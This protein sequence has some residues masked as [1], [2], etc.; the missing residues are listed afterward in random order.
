MFELGSKIQSQ[1]QSEMEKGQREYFLRQ[2]L[3]AIQQELGEGDPEQA[4]VERAARAA[5][6]AATLP[7][8][9]AQ[10]GRPRA[11]RGS[12]S[13]RRPPPSTASSA[14]TSSGSSRCRGATYT[15]DNLDLEHAREVLDADHFDLEK[16]KDRIIEYLAV[17]KLRNEVSG[18]ILCF[19]GPPGVGKT[20][21]GHSIANALGRKFVRLS[22]GGVR[23]ESEIRGHRRTYIGSMPGT[24]IRSLRDAESANPLLL[25][26]EIDKMGADWRGDPASAMLEVLD[27]EQ[28]SDVPRP[29]PRPAV[30]PLEGA[31]HLHREHARHDPRAAARP[32]G[33]DPALG[34][35]RGRE[36][37][38]RASATSSRSSSRQHGLQRAQ[39]T[40]SGQGAAHDHPRVHA[41]GRRAQPRAA[42]RRRLPQGGDRRSRQGRRDEGAGRRR[43]S[44]ASGSAPRRF[45][46]EVRKRTSDP[47]VATGLAYTAVGGD[48]L[49]IEATAYPGKGT[50]TITG[51]LGEVMQESAQAALSWV[52]SHTDELGLADG[53]VRGARRAHPR[54]GRRGAEG[55][56]R[57]PA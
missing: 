2:Q 57:R 17:A 10:G 35:H 25:I 12:R 41:R 9:V 22:V 15:E 29:L 44:C 27:P 46:G 40:L 37:R 14:P 50:L 39:L 24:I 18:Q 26:D 49:F 1:V 30:R 19:V 38:D 3:K 42:D 43:R 16:V 34:L 31:V 5:R 36:A 4:E 23:D 11:R 6:R 20:S 55:R 21:L 51:Q 8:D 53:L 33:R 48:V 45:S 52:R 56:A 32:H 13:C 54:P 47:G 7:E 28:N